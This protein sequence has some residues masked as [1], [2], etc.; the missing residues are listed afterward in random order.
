MPTVVKKLLTACG[1]NH[2]WAFKEVDNEKVTQLES[3]IQARHRKIADSF[4][5]YREITPFEFLPGH[6]DLIFA[7]KT[8]ILSFE[9]TKKLKPKTNGVPT[10]VPDEDELKQ[11]L[12]SQVSSYSSSL[13]LQL[14][15]Q[16]D[17]QVDWSNAI[18]NFKTATDGASISAECSLSCPLCN[19]V[20]VIRYDGKYWA[21]SNI[22]K[23]LRTHVKTKDKT[24]GKLNL[25]A[26]T[27]RS[28]ASNKNSQMKNNNP[29]NINKIRLGN[30]QQDGEASGK[31]LNRVEDQASNNDVQDDVPKER[32]LRSVQVSQEES[33][34]E[35]VVQ[36]LRE[37]DLIQLIQNSNI[38]HADQDDVNAIGAKE[39]LGV[40]QGVR[41]K[42]QILD[43]TLGVL[44]THQFSDSQ[45]DAASDSEQD[46]ESFY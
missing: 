23:H 46:S 41:T 36:E 20:R 30:K 28:S 26:T 3:F 21:T 15:Q 2:A 13:P 32:E 37:E 40:R 35:I 19:A 44:E 33:V 7:I 9:N 18:E 5:E 29:K 42:V 4:D 6:R 24:H 12:I 8:Q 31:V 1:Y 10:H 17:W 22:Y 25:L 11:I 38:V 16:L 43:K 34:E 39:R 27:Q 14:D 45:D